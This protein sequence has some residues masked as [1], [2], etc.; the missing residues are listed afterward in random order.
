[1]HDLSSKNDDFNWYFEKMLDKDDEEEQSLE[2][3][4]FHSRNIF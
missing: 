4:D 2:V 3:R 1:M